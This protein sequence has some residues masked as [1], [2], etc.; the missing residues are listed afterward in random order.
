MHSSLVDALC[1]PQ[2]R[3]PLVL[4]A[5]EAAEDVEVGVLACRECSH[6]FAIEDG[7]GILGDRDQLHTAADPFRPHPRPQVP[8]C[9]STTLSL[10]RL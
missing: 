10:V 1:C 9:R 8:R 3:G 2:C 7:F 5:A 6:R 4:A